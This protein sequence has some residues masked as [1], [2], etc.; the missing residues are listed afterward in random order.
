MQDRQRA[1]NKLGKRQTQI[2]D[3][4]IDLTLCIGRIERRRKAEVRRRQRLHAV[5]QAITVHISAIKFQTTLIVVNRKE[6][7][8]DALPGGL[9]LY[10]NLYPGGRSGCRIEGQ[11][12]PGHSLRR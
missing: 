9:Q 6:H 5:E 8:R 2:E 7:A 1:S 4:N 10:G 11:R 3:D 12:K